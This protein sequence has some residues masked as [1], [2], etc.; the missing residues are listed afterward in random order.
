MT[1]QEFGDLLLQI[2]LNSQIARED[3]EF[4]ITE[5]IEHI[6][7]KI[8]RRHPHVFGDVK[9]DGV[10][11]VLQNWEKLKEAE[12]SETD[13][14]RGRKPGRCNGRSVLRAGQPGAP[15]KGGRRIR[16]ARRQCK[17]QE[18]VCLCGTKREGQG[19]VKACADRQT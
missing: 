13:D 3:D 15:A 18:A 12:R 10:K 11:G 2:M 19:V 1:R 4:S 5:V 14:Q 7:D 9:L 6:Y 17:I 8:I 16:I